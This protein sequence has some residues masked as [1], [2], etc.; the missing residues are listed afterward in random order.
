MNLVKT[1]L[2]HAE[3]HSD[4][5]FK[6]TLFQGQAMMVGLNCLEPGQIQKV[7]QHE[8]QDKFYLVLKGSGRFHLGADHVEGSDGE[9][10]WA[11][12]GLEHGVENSGK[13]QLILLVGIAPAP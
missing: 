4:K 12:A 9:I 3:F 2:D 7:H 13:E 10:I 5:F 8:D 11:P 6:T 1:V